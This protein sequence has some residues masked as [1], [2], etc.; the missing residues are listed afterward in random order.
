MDALSRQILRQIQA[1]PARKRAAV[2]ELL[3]EE[4]TAHFARAG[5]E[6][7]ERAAWKASLRDLS[8]W[9]EGE[10]QGIEEARA[11]LNRWAPKSW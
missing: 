3:R 11:W 5:G 1:L 10:L 9:T 2:L 4:T 8:T 7:D 6:E